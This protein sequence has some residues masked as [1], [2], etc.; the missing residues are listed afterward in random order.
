MMDTY[1]LLPKAY[2]FKQLPFLNNFG[3]EVRKKMRFEK[4]RTAFHYFLTYDSIN[5]LH[6]ELGLCWH[7][8]LLAE[9]GTIHGKPSHFC[10][11]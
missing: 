5:S 11:F 3:I 2:S 4:L 6:S 1:G 10:L 7:P 8:I 9:S